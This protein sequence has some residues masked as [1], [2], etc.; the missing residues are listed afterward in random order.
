[1][2]A[3]GTHLWSLLADDD[4]AAVAALPDHITWLTGAFF[5][6]SGS[7]STTIGGITINT[8]WAGETHITF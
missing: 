2:V 3:G 5:N 4:M 6:G 8:D 1:M 7:S